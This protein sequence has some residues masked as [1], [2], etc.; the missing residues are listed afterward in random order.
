MRLAVKFAYDGKKFNGYARQPDQKTVEG[1]IIKSLEKNGFIEDIKESF[2]RSAS[3]TDKGVSALC[4]VIAF[5][6]N[7]DTKQLLQKL[8]LKDSSIIIYGFKEVE[9]EFNPRYAKM[10]QYRYYLKLNNLDIKKI[11]SSAAYFTGEN[12]FTNFA[13]V[14]SFKNPV[15]TIEN[16]V[17]TKE[18]NFLI[19]DFYAQTFL[20][21]Q[22]R[23]IISTLIKIGSNKIEK[24]QIIEALDY[25][26]KKFDFGLAPAEP[27][28]LKNIEY[29]F[30]FKYL[31][32]QVNKLKNFE[33]S[34][35]SYF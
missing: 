7:R 3:R 6:T 12:N 28:I 9:P 20:W 18:N 15:R 21:H 23:R 26:T 19:I 2:F 10:R 13:K 5:N 8:T 24:K 11:L 17:I 27:L 35:I 32:N 30:K 29:N 25:P 1:N 22:I 16:I 4:N 31:K 33:K 34:I 14:E